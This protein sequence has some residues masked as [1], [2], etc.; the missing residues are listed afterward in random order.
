MKMQRAGRMSKSAF[1]HFLNQC[2][3]RHTLGKE[4]HDLKSAITELEAKAEELKA[5]LRRRERPKDSSPLRSE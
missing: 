3:H 1:K 2:V 4:S 5:I